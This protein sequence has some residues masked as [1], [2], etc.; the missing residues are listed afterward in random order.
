MLK[1][2]ER[3]QKIQQLSQSFNELHAEYTQK[4]YPEMALSPIKQIPFTDNTKAAKAQEQLNAQGILLSLFRYP[5][6]QQPILRISLSW[7]HDKHD[8]ERLF[9]VM[10]QIQ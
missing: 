9:E 10:E 7:L 8:I 6:V 3:S 1:D 2:T 5:T 4:R